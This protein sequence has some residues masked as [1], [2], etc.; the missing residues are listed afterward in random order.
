MQPKSVENILATI[1]EN[2]KKARE[3]REKSLRDLASD[4]DIDH[5][6]IAKIEKGQT[7]VTIKTLH[8]LAEALEIE[9]TVL[10]KGI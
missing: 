8:V 9:F 2:L 5:S 6:A 3:S 10:L 1:G 7:N 4:C